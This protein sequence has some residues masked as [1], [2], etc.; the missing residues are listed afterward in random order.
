M[1]FHKLNVFINLKTDRMKNNFSFYFQVFNL[2]EHFFKQKLLIY[3]YFLSKAKKL[4]K[5]KKKLRKS[6]LITDNF[7]LKMLV[8]CSI[9]SFKTFKIHTRYQSHFLSI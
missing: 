3:H 7:Y 9:F 5:T 6:T 4:K 8:N 1:V 2:F